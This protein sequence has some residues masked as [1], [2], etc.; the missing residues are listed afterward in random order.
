MSEKKS[1]AEILAEVMLT[2]N[3][4]PDC[5]L[6]RNNCGSLVDKRG[7][8]VTF[9]LCKGSSDL[10]GWQ[11]VMVTPEMV[12]TRVAIFLA[13]ETKSAK[14]RASVEQNTFRDL[15]HKYG[16]RYRLLR[17]AEGISN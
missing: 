7:R 12:G 6:F 1:E 13:V 16:A 3:S 14:G 4:R 11:S 5:R 10:I 15:C 17:S 9:G 2:Y 8:L